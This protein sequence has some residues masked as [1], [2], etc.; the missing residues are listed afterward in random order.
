MP[1]QR[2]LA[3]ANLNHLKAQAK[4]LLRDYRAGAPEA[5]ALFTEFQPSPPVRDH[6]AKLSDAQLV[7]ARWRDFPSWP[8]L[9]DGVALF[10]AICADDAETVDALLAAKPELVDRPVNGATS[11]WGPPLACAAQ[12]GARRV[13][14]RLAPRHPQHLQKALDRAILMGRSELAKSLMAEGARLEAGL[15]M[16]PCETLSLDG[17][18]FLDQ[19]GAPLTDAHGDRLAPVALILEGYH[20]YPPGKHACLR[21]F[22]ERGIALPDTPVMALHRGDTQ[23]LATMLDAAP[24][25]ANATFGHRDIYPPALGCHEDPSLG[26]HG[27]P[28]DGTTLLHMAMDFDEPEIAKLLLERGADPNARAHVNDDGFGGHTP[29]FNAV[30]T[31]AALTWRKDDQMVAMLLEAG[32]DPTLR[33]SLRKAIRFHDDDSE[34]RYLNVTPLE[35]ARRFHGRAWVVQAGLDRLRAASV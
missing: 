34:H 26:L 16:G 29:L 12:L 9:V 8:K 20:R 35:Y 30:V 4:D 5:L 13:V 18:E 22:E 2:L 23:R 7:I 3:P 25:L 17:L 31:Q 32:A 11:N 15:A 27:T 21:F 1:V 24:A 10:N 19:L 14:N 6:T 33:A 28:L